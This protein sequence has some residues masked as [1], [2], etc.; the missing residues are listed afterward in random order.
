MDDDNLDCV[1]LWAAV[2]S[3]AARASRVSCAP[4]DGEHHGD[5]LQPAPTVQVFAVCLRLLCNTAA[6]TSADAPVSTPSPP[7]P[8]PAPGS[9]LALRYTD[10][11]AA[12]GSWLIVIDSPILLYGPP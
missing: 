4:S 2:D 12:A 8:P 7:P 6:T 1:A 9:R 11:V 10:V 5:V 3:A